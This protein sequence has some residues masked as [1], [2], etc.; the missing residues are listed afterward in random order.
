MRDRIEE[1]E[2]FQY[3]SARTLL[4]II[5][6]STALARLRFSETVT[7]QDVDEAIRLSEVSKA[8]LLNP[9]NK[10]KVDPI[11]QI[12]ETILGMSK[13]SVSGEFE[14]ELRYG[15]ILE[16]IKAKGFSE[17][18]LIKCIEDNEA[19]D[20]WVRTAGGNKLRW[21]MIDE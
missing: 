3:T 11:G 6:V 7:L 18:N 8:S 14:K 19:N 1:T 2:D 20:I 5:R 9:S 10:Q 17:E 12:Y 21:L 15:A 16:R 4:S 13:N